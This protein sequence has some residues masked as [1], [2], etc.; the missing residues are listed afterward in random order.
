MGYGEEPKLIP[1]GEYVGHVYDC[2]QLETKKG[3]PMILVKF[4]SEEGYSLPVFL[5]F[6][7]ATVEKFLH[8]P[9]G[10]LGVWSELKGLTS[11]EEACEKA[12][13]MIFDMVDDESKKFVITCE[14]QEYN[15]KES[16]KFNIKE[17]YV[18]LDSS[19][20]QTEV[21]EEIPF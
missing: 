8:W 12:A 3:A 10:V 16:E 18:E 13:D 6:T 15:G 7:D 14:H 21:S 4:Q 2:K 17:E 5:M 9:L 20:P 11:H 1:E 19:I